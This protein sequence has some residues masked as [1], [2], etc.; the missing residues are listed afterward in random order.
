[1]PHPLIFL[2]SAS[3]RRAQILETVGLPFVV[4]A[5][6]AVEPPPDEADE[7]AP[8]EFV[9]RLA[10]LKAQGCDLEKTRA[11]HNFPKAGKILV[12]AADTIVWHEGKIL[13]KPHDEVDATRMLQR[14]R[15]QT[16]TVFT[17]VC[18]RVVEPEY[19]RTEQYS[20]A[21]Q[22]SCAHEATRVQFGEAGDAW[23]E[24]YVASGEPMDKA[25]AYAA[26][27]R[28]AI[29][30]ERI[31]GDFWNVVGLPIARVARML[32]GAGAPVEMW[33]EESSEF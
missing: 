15:G 28:G 3:P 23:I 16:H 25:G 12:L 13:S 14:L 32:K 26:Q 11:L 9:E 7:R 29:L 10:R 33:W 19:C 20:P 4:A 1:M 31:E 24:K 18:L 21:E 17:G 2:A 30:I 27:G 5:S 6:D 22:Y 8:Q